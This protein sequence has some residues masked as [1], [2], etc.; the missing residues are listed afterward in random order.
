MINHLRLKMAIKMMT[1]QKFEYKT[2]GYNNPW[3]S[4]MSITTYFTQ[5]DHFQVSLRDCGIT[6]SDREKMWQR[7]LKCGSPRYSWKIKWSHGKIG[8]R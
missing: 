8:H 1:A 2:N 4:T 5:L 6:T 3:D 7:A